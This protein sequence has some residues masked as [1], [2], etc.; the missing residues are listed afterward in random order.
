[1]SEKVRSSLITNKSYL[2]FSLKGLAV[3]NLCHNDIKP[4]NYLT[5][6]PQ[7]QT[8][9]TS[10]LKIYLTDFGM[11]DR[12]GGTPVY[13]SPEGL[14]S[15]VPG[16][17]DMFSLGRVF[18]FLIMEDRSL[19]YILTFFS[20]KNSSHLQF[21]RNFMTSFPIMNLIKEMTHIDAN[22]RIRIA[23]VEQRL[24]NMNIEIMTRTSI[25][26]E[27]GA[28][29][30]ADLSNALRRAEFNDHQVKEMMKER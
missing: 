20:I 19:F 8:P 2:I 14:T 5:D 9:T 30:Q 4:S 10:N 18:T 29:N 13:S 16:V 1:M 23:Q 7:G 22:K 21:I 15:A 28:R 11:V 26:S 12:S 25:A 3:A 6:W 17:S 24:T 27:L